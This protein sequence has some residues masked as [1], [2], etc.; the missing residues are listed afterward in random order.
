M[1][2]G[3]E[4]E[5]KCERSAKRQEVIGNILVKDGGKIGK[6]NKE[7]RDRSEEE[8]ERRRKEIFQREMYVMYEMYK[9]QF[10]ELCV[11]LTLERRN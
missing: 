1:K 4:L 9:I 3:Y 5:R 10:K 11:E 2:Q 8:N 6:G 7:G